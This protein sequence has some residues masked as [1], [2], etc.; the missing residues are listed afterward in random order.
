MMNVDDIKIDHQPY[1]DMGLKVAEYKPDRNLYKPDVDI[2][3]I[4]IDTSIHEAIGM[5]VISGPIPEWHIKLMAEQRDKAAE[6][7]EWPKDK[8]F[9]PPGITLE[10]A[11]KAA[12]LCSRTD[13]TDRTDRKA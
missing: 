3:D 4:K 6:D 7:M 13:R 9:D 1:L 11:C 8:L 5:R 12:E 2:N 10:E